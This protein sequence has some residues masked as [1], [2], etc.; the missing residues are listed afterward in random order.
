MSIRG[1]HRVET[2]SSQ[3]VNKKIPLKT[4]D[5]HTLYEFL[6]IDVGQEPVPDEGQTLG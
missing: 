4:N 5:T 3:R 6:G 2:I 1:G